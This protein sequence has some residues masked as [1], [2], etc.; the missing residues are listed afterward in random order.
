MISLIVQTWT[1]SKSTPDQS[2][3]ILS[4]LE[5]HLHMNKQKKPYPCTSYFLTWLI[6]A[7]KQYM[8]HL[9]NY[10]KPWTLRNHHETL[11][12]SEINSHLE[13]AGLTVMWPSQTVA[14]MPAAFD[15]T[16]LTKLMLPSSIWHF[17][18][19]TPLY[20]N[21]FTYLH[22]Q[23]FIT[24]LWVKTIISQPILISMHRRY[25]SSSCSPQ[26]WKIE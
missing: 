16:G 1:S 9:W 19:L 24:K 17:A 14:T 2:P 3:A 18:E 4:Y 11:I 6:L 5:I 13:S 23:L 20:Q 15:L 21:Q 26:L 12:H 22:K 8:I 7:H 25:V 10:W